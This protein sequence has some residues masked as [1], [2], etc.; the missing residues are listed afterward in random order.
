MQPV[1]DDEAAFFNSYEK[2]IEEIK[3]ALNENFRAFKRGK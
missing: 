3:N 1:S 2:S